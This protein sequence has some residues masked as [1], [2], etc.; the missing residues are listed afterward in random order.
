LWPVLS[1]FNHRHPQRTAPEDRDARWR[2]YPND[3]E[4]VLAT[5][6]LSEFSELASALRVIQV[7]RHTCSCARTKTH[8]FLARV[9]AGGDLLVALGDVVMVH[10][11]RLLPRTYQRAA[12]VMIVSLT[13]LPEAHAGLLDFLFGHQA[14]PAHRWIELP[15]PSVGS[16]RRA[17]IF[18]RKSAVHRQSGSRLQTASCCRDGGDPVTALMN[19]PT[20]RKGDAVMMTQGLMIFEGSNIETPHQ[21]ADFVGVLTASLSSKKRARI[22]APSINGRMVGWQP[23]KTAVSAVDVARATSQP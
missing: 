3:S 11:L 14:A 19:D 5:E 12:I 6:N 7:Y 2:E 13:P 20:L 15:P 18:R 23:V 1:T 10:V 17:A 22:L 21:P 16:Y 4:R 8:L 9:I